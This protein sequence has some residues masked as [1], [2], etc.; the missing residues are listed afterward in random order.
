VIARRGVRDTA[1]V[2]ER[3]SAATE[4]TR[5][6]VATRGDVFDYDRTVALSDGVFAIALTLLV[7]NIPIPSGDGDLWA[8]LDDLLPDLG[9]YALSFVV[10][11]TMWRYHHVFCRELHRINA[12]LTSLNLLYLGLIALIPFPTGLIAERGDESAAVIV[13]ALTIALV[14]GLASAMDLYAQRAGLTAPRRRPRVNYFVVPGVFVASIPL[15][16]I[17]PSLGLYSWLT[18]PVLGHLIDRRERVRE[19]AAS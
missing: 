6:A 7:L 8:Q 9:A 1:R 10:I 13:Y 5:P 3:S 15:A 4:P 19:R 16:A 11:A 14:T 12:R 18:L 17:E 2:A